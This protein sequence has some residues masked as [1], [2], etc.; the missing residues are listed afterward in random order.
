[1]RERLIRCLATGFYSGLV[2]FAPGLAGSVVGLGYWWLLKWFGST[3]YWLI[4]VLVVLFA[5]W[6][7]GMAAKAMGQKDPSCVVIDETAAVP[8]A[9]AGLDG[10]WWIV[11]FVL[12]RVFDVWKPPGIRQSQQLPG[13]WGIVADDLLAAVAACGLTRVMVWL[14]AR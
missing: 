7:S 3:W 11:G 8:V 9:L 1:M 10:W 14:A 2:P 4:V 13:G 5:V 12:F 6:C